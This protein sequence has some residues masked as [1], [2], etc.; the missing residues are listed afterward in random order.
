MTESCRFEN[1]RLKNT[2]A[3]LHDSIARV[4][5]H[6]TQTNNDTIRITIEH[7]SLNRGTSSFLRYSPESV[8]SAIR[9]SISNLSDDVVRVD[10][11]DDASLGVSESEL[12]GRTGAIGNS[13]PEISEVNYV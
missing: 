10:L 2:R 1:G 11:I 7:P 6:D 12:L 5:I 9:N 3:T 13:G 4:L 8:P